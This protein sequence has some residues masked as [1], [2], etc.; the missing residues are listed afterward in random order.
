MSSACGV[1][2]EDDALI[3]RVGEWLA[4][5]QSSGLPYTTEVL[6]QQFQVLPDVFSPRFYSETEFYAEALA[7]QFRPGSVLL[8]VGC[9]TG[10][11]LIVAARAGAK[12]VALDVNPAAVENTRL[13]VELH[14]VGDRVVA[15]VSDVFSGVEPGERF[16]LV[17]W[18]VQFTWRA[19]GTRLSPLEESI[20]D[21]RYRKNRRLITEARALLAPGGT[22]LLG[23][24][25]T[26]GLADAVAELAAAAEL[27]IRL[28]AETREAGTTEVL[29]LVSLEPVAHRAT[30]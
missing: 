29:Q 6:G 23:I 13:N 8:D 26:L 11:N 10:V 17:Y 30:D 9:G 18:N 16:D 20:F 4:D 15:R 7:S 1:P 27:S 28:V 3:C 24:A 5:T 19:P 22:V 14:R 25:P 21:P 2:A 12:V